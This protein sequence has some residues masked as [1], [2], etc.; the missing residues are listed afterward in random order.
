MEVLNLNSTI[1]KIIVYEKRFKDG[2][3]MGNI[4]LHFNILDIQRIFFMHF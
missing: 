1:Y 4:V 3:L 2:G